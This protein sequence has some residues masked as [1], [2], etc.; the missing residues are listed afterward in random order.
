MPRPTRCVYREGAAQCRRNGLGN[1]PLCRP[2][3]TLFENDL[4]EASSVGSRLGSVIGKLFRGHRIT[5]DEL[6][7][8]FVD[9]L[10][11]A[12]A[13]G[14][15]AAAQGPVPGPN[16]P[17]RRS[18]ADW[19][20]EQLRQ[21]QAQQDAE[22]QHAQAKAKATADAV[23]KAKV[24]LGWKAADTPSVEQINR[25]RRELARKHHP[26]RKGGSVAKMQS[27]NAAA[28]LLLAQLEPQPTA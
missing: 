4:T 11:M 26:D 5:N 16:G 24:E 3:R 6:G 17:P 23:K 1:P 14:G 10:R 27:I 20:Y 28:D 8:A 13:V 9:G 15:A 12:G 21:R 18:V 7:A 25:R 19:A 2:H 22:Q